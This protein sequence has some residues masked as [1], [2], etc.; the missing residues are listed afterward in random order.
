MSP[1]FIASTSNFGQTDFDTN[2]A[3]NGCRESKSTVIKTEKVENYKEDSMDNGDKSDKETTEKDSPAFRLRP[4]RSTSTP[5]TPSPSNSSPTKRLST[6]SAMMRK[7]AL[8]KRKL[9]FNVHKTYPSSNIG[10]EISEPTRLVPPRSPSMSIKEETFISAFFERITVN[11]VEADREYKD[12]YLTLRIV[13]REDVKSSEDDEILKLT[14]T[15]VADDDKSEHVAKKQKKSPV[16]ESSSSPKVDIY[17]HGSY[18]NCKAETGKIINV[19]KFKTQARETSND[20]EGKSG[21]LP[22]A[23]IVKSTTDPLWV[24]FISITSK[25]EIVKDPREISDTLLNPPAPQSSSEHLHVDDKA[26]SSKEP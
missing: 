15:Q 6:L 14:A 11:E 21:F 12:N 7:Q 8:V 22:F 17:L 20:S 25:S 24:P 9:V 2:N 26:S 23:I 18:V 4:R 10:A 13:S 5:L 1:P 16:K 19:A 3:N